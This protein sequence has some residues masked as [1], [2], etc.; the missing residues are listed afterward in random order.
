MN[1]QRIVLGGA[2]LDN[3]KMHDIAPI[4]NAE[5]F[6]SPKYQ[7]LYKLILS[8]HDERQP[9]DVI[10]IADR[11]GDKWIAEIG[12]LVSESARVGN[13]V[14]HAKLILD[15]HKKTQIQNQLIESINKINQKQDTQTIVNDLNTF[16]ATL[17]IASA[18][19]LRNIKESMDQFVDGLDERYKL[20]GTFKGL[21]TGLKDLDNSIQGMQDGNLIIIAGR[22]AMGKSVLAQNIASHNAINENKTVLF[23]SLEMT[24]EE[25][26][27]RLVSSVAGADYGKIQSARCVDDSQEMDLIGD[28][29]GRIKKGS[30]IIDDSSSL[31][32]AELKAKS[33]SYAR[34]NNGVDLIVVDYLQLLSAKAESRFQEVSII[35]RQLKS[36][37]KEIGCPV[38]ALSQLSRSLE[39]RGDKRP[40]MSD[41]RESGQLEQDADKIIFIY[42]DEVYNDKTPAKEL[43]EIIIGKARNCPKQNVVS[44][45]HGSQQ[46]FRNADYN[47]YEIIEGLKEIKK[48]G[49]F[50]KQYRN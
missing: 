18:S 49:D 13:P 10:S 5:H 6:T 14:H 24:E 38:I 39:S 50:A 20:N 22:P 1:S 15:N 25:I 4:L 31:S 12:K 8:F 45:F 27:Q 11:I 32:I 19:K 16:L 36:L 34:K 30:F 7:T 21:S 26:Q 9:F 42:R 46:T 35:S 48:G 43:A 3:E 17:D 23:F 28:A 29:I 41:L 2:I 47:C 37:A 33:I 44:R 40:I